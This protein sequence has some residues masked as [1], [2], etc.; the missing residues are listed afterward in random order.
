MSSRADEL[1]VDFFA[2]G[3]GASAGIEMAL[4]RSPDIAVNHDAEAV[5]MHRANHP[6]TIHLL[7][8]VFGVR[9]ELDRLIGDRP[10]GLFWA[11]PDCKHFSKAK[12]GRPVKRRIRDLAWVVPRFAQRFRPRVIVLENV[13]EFR[14]WGPLVQKRDPA[15]AAM[16]DI[17]GSPVMVPCKRRR[18]ET[19]AQWVDSLQRLGYRVEWRELRACNYG[20]PTIRKRLFIIARRD[21]RPIVWPA[22]TH[23]DPKAKNFAESGLRPWRTAAEV[24][25]WSLPCHSIFLSREEGR[26]SGVKRPLAD[27]TMARIAKGVKRYV[28]D[29]EKPFLVSLTHHGGDR[30]EDLAEPFKTITSAHR[31]EKALVSPF[32]TR[33]NT[34]ATGSAAT[35]PLPTVTANSY[36][37]RPGGAPTLGVV[38]PIITGGGGRMGQTEP[39]PADRPAQTLTAKADS[40]LVAP[41]LMTMRNAQKPHNEADKPAHTVTA[42]GAHLNLV[43]AFLAKHYGDT[44]Q[45]P[46]SEMVE[47]VATITAADH[48]AVVSAGLINQKGSDQRHAAVD[49]PAPAICAGGR[50]VGHVV[51][52]LVKYYGQSIVAGLAEPAHTVTTKDRFGLVQIE[53]ECGPQTGVAITIGGEPFVI[54][55]IGMRMLTARELFGAQGF[56]P[57]YVIAFG[58]FLYAGGKP[59]NRRLTATAQIRMVGNSVSPPLARALAAANVPE[60]AIAEAVA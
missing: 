17:N 35:E 38:A 12:G 4:G 15:G 23:G 56:A 6:Q 52:F 57:A 25:D 10:V 28:I 31:G 13:E 16:L 8:D 43:A 27:A 32:V 36:V 24:I 53:T 33:F 22:P 40:V 14:E 44:G 5:A 58:V 11:S 1:I 42:E 47:P 7:R 3:G 51:A 54:A 50:H 2:G 26:A 21:G 19:F 45:R 9:A 39:R 49:T 18:G 59:F 37:K 29:A 46:G 20:A 41:H 48:N 30:T 34:G 55:D 60:L